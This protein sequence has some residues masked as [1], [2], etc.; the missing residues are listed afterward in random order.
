M[1][2]RFRRTPP[3]GSKLAM[4]HDPPALAAGFGLSPILRF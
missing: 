2:L 1:H 3:G 4:L